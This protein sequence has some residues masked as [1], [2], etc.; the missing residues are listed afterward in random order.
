MRLIFR[1]D[2]CPENTVVVLEWGDGQIYTQT[3]IRVLLIYTSRRLRLTLNVIKP[4][5]HKWLTF[6]T[7]YSYIFQTKICY[8]SIFYNW[9]RLCAHLTLYP[10]TDCAAVTG[11]SGVSGRWQLSR[12]SVCRLSRYAYQFTHIRQRCTRPWTDGCLHWLCS[13]NEQAGACSS[14]APDSIEPD[15]P[16]R[17]KTSYCRGVFGRCRRHK[18]KSRKARFWLVSLICC[19]YTNYHQVCIWAFCSPLS[20]SIH[21]CTRNCMQFQFI[22]H[23]YLLFGITLRAVSMLTLNICVCC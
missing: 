23:R 22:L 9:K 10:A 12:Y 14:S 6:H 15:S 21:S 5:P 17:R 13:P 1:C 2:L 4:L 18:P 3:H 8:L 11:I 20:N 16:V 7:R 19:P